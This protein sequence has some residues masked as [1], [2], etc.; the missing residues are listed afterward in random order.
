M[1]LRFR[2]PGANAYA[3]KGA[4]GLA[5]GDADDQWAFDLGRSRDFAVP[6]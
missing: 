4:A 6:D 2:V 3:P 1:L 5:A